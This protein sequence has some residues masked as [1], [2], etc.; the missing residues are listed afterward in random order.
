MKYEGKKTY[1]ESGYKKQIIII[2][3]IKWRYIYGFSFY[4]YYILTSYFSMTI[5]INYEMTHIDNKTRK[6]KYDM[7][8]SK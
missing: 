3:K 5:N 1:M 4:M 7:K 2:N 6:K 8:K